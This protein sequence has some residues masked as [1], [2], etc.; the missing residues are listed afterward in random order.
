MEKPL[1]KVFPTKAG[2]FT[3]EPETFS[4]DKR[5]I[6]VATEK[7]AKPRVFIPVF[8]GTNCEYDTARAFENAG[9]VADVFVVRNLTGD[10]V[11]YS[12]KEMQKRINNSQIVMIPGGF[13]GG[14]EPEGS[15]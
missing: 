6:T 11:V 3:S 4:Y 10:D 8:P 1:E 9:A 12:M 2:H 13:S 7:F 14:D 15:G 5:N